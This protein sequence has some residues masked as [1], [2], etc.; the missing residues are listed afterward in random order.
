MRHS[1]ASSHLRYAPME[2]RRASP[3]VRQPESIASTRLLTATIS[4]SAGR[5]ASPAH[6][7]LCPL[8]CTVTLTPHHS[9]TCQVRQCHHPH[10]HPGFADL[11]HCVRLKTWPIQTC[12]GSCCILCRA[13]SASHSIWICGGAVLLLAH[14][15]CLPACSLT[16]MPLEPAVKDI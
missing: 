1:Q 3:Q 4:L 2:S 8:F 5:A 12:T 6:H 11:L 13:A 9:A 15:T 14:T 16:H 10:P 7:L